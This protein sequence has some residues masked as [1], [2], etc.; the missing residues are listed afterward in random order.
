VRI[1]IQTGKADRLG[2]GRFPAPSA[3]LA[4]AFFSAAGSAYAQTGAILCTVTENGA[5]ARGTFEAEQSGKEIGSGSCGDSLAVPPGKYRVSVTLDGALDSPTKSADVA[6]TAGKTAPLTI[7]FKTGVLEVRVEAKAQGGTAQ[8]NVNRGS[9][10]IG[11]IG[12]NVPARL[13]TGAYEVVVRLGGQERRFA[14][15]LRPGQ[16]RLVRAQF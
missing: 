3:L 4:L 5:P 2:F 12:S 15:D 13:S 6:V 14:V 16:R 10:R 1:P 7:D 9:E 8:I 11:T